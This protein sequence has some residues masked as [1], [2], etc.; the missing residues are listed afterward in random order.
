MKN[1]AAP[2]FQ[3]VKRTP[4]RRMPPAAQRIFRPSCQWPQK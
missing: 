2:G 4:S 3:G 1:V